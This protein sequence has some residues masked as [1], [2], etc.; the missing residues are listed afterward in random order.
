MCAADAA[1]MEEV[2]GPGGDLGTN[3]VDPSQVP[4]VFDLFHCQL[5]SADRASSGVDVYMADCI[6]H[7][8]RDQRI[9]EGAVECRLVLRHYNRADLLLHGGSTAW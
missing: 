6:H 3:S 2:C 5:I 8:E 9:A 4:L 7:G 1:G